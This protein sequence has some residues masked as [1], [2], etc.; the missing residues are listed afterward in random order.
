MPRRNVL[1]RIAILAPIL[2]TAALFIRDPDRFLAPKFWAE[3]GAIFFKDAYE[4]GPLA[5]VRPHARAIRM[6]G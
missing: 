4:M 2:V 1:P 5:L 3:D 6:R